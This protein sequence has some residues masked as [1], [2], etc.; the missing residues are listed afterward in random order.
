MKKRDKLIVEMTM[1]E[2][3]DAHDAAQEALRRAKEIEALKRSSKKLTTVIINN[4]RIETTNPST[5]EQYAKE[6]KSTFKI[7]K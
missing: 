4:C 6:N 3:K 1:E 2:K 7:E 5:Y